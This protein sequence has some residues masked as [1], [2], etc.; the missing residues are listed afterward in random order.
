MYRLT[1][2]DI[3]YPAHKEFT[4]ETS[5]KVIIFDGQMHVHLK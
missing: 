2:T 3:N 1:K 5:E 4:A